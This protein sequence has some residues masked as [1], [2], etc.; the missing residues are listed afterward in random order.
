MSG[1]HYY[2]SQKCR[3]LTEHYPAQSEE[4]YMTI[5]GT[6]RCTPNQYFGPTNRRGYH[7]HAILSGEGI[8]EVGNQEYTMH[9]GQLFL[10]KPGEW[11]YYY[12]KPSNPW[13][14]CW[15][16]F[17]GTKAGIL[18]EQAGFTAGV[19]IRSCYVDINDFY[20]L[21]DKI[22]MNPELSMS[23]YIMRHGFMFSYIGAAIRSYELSSNA[24]RTAETSTD[25]YIDHA[26]D[27]IWNNYSSITVQDI[28]NYIRINRSY[29]SNLFRQRVGISPQ[30]YLQRARMY[31]GA[32]LLSNTDL[33]IRD[34]SEMV[35]YND[36]LTF[37]KAFKNLYGVSPKA[38][39]NQ[40]VEDR[41]VLDIPY[42]QRF[43]MNTYNRGALK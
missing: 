3:C 42:Q 1:N 33:A 4:L 24:R 28:S 8:L 9:A 19:N 35:G 37:S 26:L 13:T 41:A 38:Y 20:K 12:A 29:F 43:Q 31:K 25:A 14:Y 27:F 18:M 23:S 21:V 6:E 17:E 34:I 7:L 5:C 32:Q 15:V 10:E 16:T 40:P 11:T 2:E 36:P 22:L 39:R 30:E